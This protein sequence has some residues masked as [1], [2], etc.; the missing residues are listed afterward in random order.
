MVMRYRLN[1]W[2]RLVEHRHIVSLEKYAK[3]MDESISIILDY[4]EEK[5]SSVVADRV[6]RSKVA[7]PRDD[8][9]SSTRKHLTRLTKNINARI[10]PLNSAF[11]VNLLSSE[12]VADDQPSPL[13]NPITREALCEEDGVSLKHQ[14]SRF[15]FTRPVC[16]V[17]HPFCRRQYT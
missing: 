13:S 4:C 8:K 15:L 16:A 9:P 7:L 14:S 6:P 3:K 1:L 2:K 10:E 11:N 17:Y 5:M 12:L